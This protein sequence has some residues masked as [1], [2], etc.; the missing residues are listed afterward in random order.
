MMDTRHETDLTSNYVYIWIPFTDWLTTW[1]SVIKIEN[2]WFL[3]ANVEFLKY[4]I[5]LCSRRM[6][7]VEMLTIPEYISSPPGLVGE[8]ISSPPGLVGYLFLNHYIC[9]LSFVYHCSCFFFCV[10][11][12]SS[13]YGF[14]LPLWYLQ[15]FLSAR[16]LWGSCCSFCWFTV[17][18]SIGLFVF[19]LCL[20][21]N[22]ASVSG[23][24]ILGCTFGFL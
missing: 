10:V 1:P 14:W 11:C 18:C 17:L 16:H 22:V 3:R 15:T 8:Y 5:A 23:L 2:Y 13:I 20:V 7:L 24:S 4:C 9:A 6:P 21:P 12:P 19:V